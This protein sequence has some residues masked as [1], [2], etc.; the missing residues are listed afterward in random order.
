MQVKLIGNFD[1][2]FVWRI[3]VAAHE[4]IYDVCVA[5]LHTEVEARHVNLAQCSILPIMAA[6]IGR[7]KAT[8][9]FVT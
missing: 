8:V 4:N 6:L 3:G 9:T 2:A 5:A 1:C 7:L